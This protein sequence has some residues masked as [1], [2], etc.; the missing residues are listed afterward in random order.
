M[1]P[2]RGTGIR[3]WPAWET[4]FPDGLTLRLN[5]TVDPGALLRE[6]WG[7]RQKGHT[8]YGIPHKYSYLPISLSK[9]CGS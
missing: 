6:N 3:A 5:L 2:Y 8:E 4:W 7:F 1:R 9:Y